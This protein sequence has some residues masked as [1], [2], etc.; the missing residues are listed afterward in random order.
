MHNKFKEEQRESRKLGNERSLLNKHMCTSCSS[1]G[2]SKVSFVAS[3]VFSSTLQDRGVVH[4]ESER[5]L[6]LGEWAINPLEVQ[7][8]SISTLRLSFDFLCF[9]CRRF[10]VLSIFKKLQ[11]IVNVT[12]ASHVTGTFHYEQAKLL[13]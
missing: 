11:K 4:S 1:V 7:P 8:L 9:E 2:D 5:G 6:G 3:R 12:L 10:G 13:G